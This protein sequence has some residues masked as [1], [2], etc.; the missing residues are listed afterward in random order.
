LRVLQR[1]GTPNVLDKLINIYFNTSAELFHSMHNSLTAGDAAGLSSAAHSLKSSS[2]N[3]GAL[4]LAALCQQME[5]F[6]REC[7][8]ARAELLMADIETE[9]A[10]VC[11]SLSTI[12][13]ETSL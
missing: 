3:L 4:N 12:Q 8:L 7:T 9:Y 1:A 2:A 5:N 10:A 11:E 6:G 13:R